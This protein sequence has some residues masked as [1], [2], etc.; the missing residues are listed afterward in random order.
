MAI[1]LVAAS[2]NWKL[3]TWNTVK[4]LV[5]PFNRLYLLALQATAQ[6]GTILAYGPKQNE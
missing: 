4:G 6:K 3:Y 5:D 1:H 2:Q